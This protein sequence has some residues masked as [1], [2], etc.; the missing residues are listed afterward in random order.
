MVYLI[1]VIWH[2]YI[3][4]G[5]R[6]LYTLSLPTHK[7]TVPGFGLPDITIHAHLDTQDTCTQHMATC[8][9]H[10]EIF[11]IKGWHNWKWSMFAL[12][13]TDYNRIAL[14]VYHIDAIIDILV[15]QLQHTAFRVRFLSMAEQYAYQWEKKLRYICSVSFIGWYIAYNK[16][17]ERKNIT[18]VNFRLDLTE[19]ILLGQVIGVDSS[20]KSLSDTRPVNLSRT[21]EHGFV[22]QWKLLQL[23]GL[24]NNAY[25][26]GD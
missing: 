2:L 24:P 25:D 19:L 5:P 14:S 10:K 16:K 7:V 11:H 9:P 13:E 3:A 1:L 12:K 15:I 6:R 21:Q 17:E 8:G 26:F 18:K 23:P 22:H 4:S 20:L